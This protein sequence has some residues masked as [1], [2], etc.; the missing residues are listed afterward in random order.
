[1]LGSRLRAYSGRFMPNRR[2]AVPPSAV[3]VG[4]EDGLIKSALE[5]L[6]PAEVELGLR[7]HPAVADA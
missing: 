6:Y 1:M 3:F 5:N 4:P 7:E 2:A